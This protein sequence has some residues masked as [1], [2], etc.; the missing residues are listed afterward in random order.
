M[1]TSLTWV[2]RSN[3]QSFVFF[4]FESSPQF[5]LVDSDQALP[6]FISACLVVV[7]VI[8]SQF[9]SPTSPIT[10]SRIGQGTAPPTVSR[11]L[12]FQMDEC[13]HLAPNIHPQQM[14][15]TTLPRA[16]ADCRRLQKSRNP[17]KEKIGTA[18]CV[19]MS[20]QQILTQSDSPTTLSFPD[21]HQWQYFQSRIT[22]APRRTQAGPKYLSTHL[23][24]IP[25]A[26][27]C[28]LFSFFTGDG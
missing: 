21:H 5:D 16:V 4:F 1:S 12:G 14:A 13:P 26:V 9:T 22:G 18:G 7:I 10:S 25:S 2:T 6:R 20:I 3:N 8:V 19:H 23:A 15:C 17:I 28:M 11:S 27:V 24:E